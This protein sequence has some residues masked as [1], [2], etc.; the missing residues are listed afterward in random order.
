MGSGGS[1]LSTQLRVPPGPKPYYSRT[2]PGDKVSSK[3]SENPRYL[4]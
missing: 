4:I 3:D 2:N 1:T